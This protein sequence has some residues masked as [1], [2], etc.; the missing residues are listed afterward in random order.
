M[1]RPNKIVQLIVSR[2]NE[3]IIDLIK[4]GHKA[5]DIAKVFQSTRESNI[6]KIRKVSFYEWVLLQKDRNDIVG[7][8][9]NDIKNDSKAK[10]IP[11]KR[12]SWF[13]YLKNTSAI[14]ACKEA[15]NEYEK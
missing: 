14:E 4:E 11:N 7:D 13:L 9:A 6:S 8:L 2:R 12:G 5:I 3:L 1:A 15:W 10:D